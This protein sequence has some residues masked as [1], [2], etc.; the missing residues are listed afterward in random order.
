MVNIFL[1]D[2]GRRRIGD[3]FIVAKL[4]DTSPT[5]PYSDIVD[6]DF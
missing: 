5:K 3:R 6:A 1:S 4:D 2:T